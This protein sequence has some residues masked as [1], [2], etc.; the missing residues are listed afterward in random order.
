MNMMLDP[1]MQLALRRQQLHA[2]AEHERL[3][4]LLPH[5]ESRVRRELALACVRLANWLDEPAG[6]VQLPDA[7][8]EDWAAPWA[9]V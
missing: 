3:L 9:S 5:R 1:D 8:R 6:Y 7:G 2:E 4:S